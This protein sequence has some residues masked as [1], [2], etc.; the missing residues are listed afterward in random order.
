VG[1]EPVL[2]SGS[3]KDNIAYGLR[4]CEDAQVMAAAQAACADD[5]IGEMTNGINTGTYRS[6][7]HPGR[8]RR[9]WG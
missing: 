7:D 4:D 1:Q 8:G 3:V 5:F 6:R 2:F 9:K